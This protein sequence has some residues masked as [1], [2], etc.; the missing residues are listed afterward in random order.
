MQG[1]TKKISSENIILKKRKLRNNEVKNN[2]KL[3]MV[4]HKMKTEI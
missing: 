4:K 2:R 1:K 3:K